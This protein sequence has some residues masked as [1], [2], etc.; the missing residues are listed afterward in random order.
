MIARLLTLRLLFLIAVR[1]GHPACRT[2][3]FDNPLLRQRADPHVILHT[4]GQYYFTATVPEY[5]RIEIRRTRDLNGCATAETK[6]IWRKHASGPMSKHIWAPEIHHIEG[7]WYIY[8]TA[9]RVD[10]IWEIRPH[11]LDERVRRSVQ[12]RME[13]ARPAQHRMGELLARRDHVRAQGQAL[14]RLDAA[15]TDA[16]RRQGHQHLSCRDELTDH[17]HGQGRTADQARYEWEKRK[18]QVNE[19]PAVLI[20]NGTRLHDL[21]RQRHQRRLLRGIAHRVRGRG[22]ARS[23]IVEEDARTRFSRPARRTAIYGPGHNSYTTTPDGKTD[24]FVYHGREYRDIVGHELDDPNRHTRAQV[25]KWK[26]TARPISASPKRTAARWP[27][28]R[29]SAIRLRRRRRSGS[30]LHGLVRPLV[31]VLY[32]SPRQPQATR[33]VE[34]VHGTRIGIAES[35]DAGATWRYVGEADIEIPPE[36]GGERC[37]AL[38]AGR[39]ARRRRHIPHVPHRGAGHLRQTGITRADRAPDEQGSA[40]L[41][42]RDGRQARDRSRHRCVGD[43]AARGGWRMYYNNEPD[44]KSIWY[45]DSPDLEHWTDRGKLIGDQAGEGPKVIPVARQVVA[46]H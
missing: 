18:Y 16:G 39:G 22:S 24:I 7:K 1:C 10:A 13:R 15:R 6:V 42:R 4:D 34:W 17:D 21:F 12:G 43:P 28:N 46:H 44:R 26:P 31:H 30:G 36:F 35:L 19:G 5:D 25:L 45:A 20:R 40:H 32:E 3:E 29:C 8:F 41:A 27:P 33:G 37:D 2:P 23:R 38:G 9:S 14:L 11:A